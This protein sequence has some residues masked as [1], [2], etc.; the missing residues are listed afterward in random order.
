[1]QV[2]LEFAPVG[3]LAAHDQLLEHAFFLRI[4]QTLGNVFKVMHGLVRDP[5]L[6]VSCIV[7]AE[8]ITAAMTR[9]AAEQPVSFRQFVQA[10]I[11][12]PRPL[13]IDQGHTHSRLRSQ[14]RRQRLEM[15]APVNE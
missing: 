9:Q 14:K 7:A 8:S 6:R 13:P 15:K 11:E 10:Q 12:K 2:R 1:M 3:L 4:F 5:A